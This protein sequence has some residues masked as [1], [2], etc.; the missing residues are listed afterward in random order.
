[1]SIHCEKHGG[2]WP[3]YWAYCEIDEKDIR[4]DDL[5]LEASKTNDLINLANVKRTEELE[6][7]DKELEEQK[8]AVKK[9]EHLGI[10]TFDHVIEVF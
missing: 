2:L 5:E 8:Q 4:I 9:M 10:A 3:R 1:M 7:R 6:A